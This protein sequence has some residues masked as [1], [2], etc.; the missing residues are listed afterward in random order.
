MKLRTPKTKLLL[1]SACAAA[2]LSMGL[3]TTHPTTAFS[4]V[5]DGAALFKANCASCHGVDG[6]GAT[7][8]G[9]SMK[10]RDLRSPEVQKL[11]DKQLTDLTAKGKGKMPGYEAKLGADKVKLLVAYTRELAKK[12]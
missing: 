3:L 7:A 8:V 12:K 2:V 4:A 11:T 1:F 10:L 5:Q 9:K 6:S